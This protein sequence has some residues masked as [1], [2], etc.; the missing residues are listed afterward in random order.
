[1]YIFVPLH[2]GKILHTGTY[3][4]EEVPV[5]C[6]VLAQMTVVY[7]SLL[8]RLYLCPAGTDTVSRKKQLFQ[9]FEGIDIYTTV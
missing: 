5:L 3:K 1:M 7:S 9:H 8:C 2:R 4:T 6:T